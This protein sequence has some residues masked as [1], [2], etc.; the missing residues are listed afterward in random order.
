M[1]RKR[2]ESELD[3]VLAMA[4]AHSTEASA[5][6]ARTRSKDRKLVLEARSTAFLEVVMFIEGMRAFPQSAAEAQT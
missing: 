3:R 6:L 4:Q 1:K 5:K 2:P